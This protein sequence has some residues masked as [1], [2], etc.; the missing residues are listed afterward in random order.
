MIVKVWFNIRRVES[1]KNMT[2]A[3]Q[4]PLIIFFFFWEPSDIRNNW[5]VNLKGGLPEKLQSKSTLSCEIVKI[6]SVSS[7]F[8]KETEIK[9]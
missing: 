5:S 3:R 8:Y 2:F 6:Q 1:S 7:W 9:I 4:C